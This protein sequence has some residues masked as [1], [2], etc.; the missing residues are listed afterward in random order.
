MGEYGSYDEFI[1]KKL[2]E[3]PFIRHLF[4]RLNTEVTIQTT[5]IKIRGILKTIDIS[6]RWF[7]VDA[8]EPIKKT[9]FLKWDFIVYVESEHS[10][11]VVE[12]KEEF[13]RRFH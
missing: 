12:Q 2:G 10:Q 7:E 1:K 13:P 4:A 9:F 5:D 11:Q 6:Y 3:S 8:V